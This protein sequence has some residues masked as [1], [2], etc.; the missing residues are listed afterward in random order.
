[1]LA[2]AFG[3]DEKGGGDVKFPAGVATLDAEAKSQLE[4]IAKSLKDRPALKLTVAGSASTAQEAQGWKAANLEAQ[5]AK[6]GKG[7]EDDAAL[8]DKERDSRLKSIYRKADIEKPRNMVGLSKSLPPEEMR[9]LLVEQLPL[10]PTAMQELAAAR[11]MA[12]RSY[13]GQQGID[14]ARLFL[15]DSKADGK[16]A[17]AKAQ[18]SLAV[19]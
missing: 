8:S 11:A 18:L 16:E 13:L 2:G 14:M 9:K 3:G 5:I 19:Q 17:G 4:K 1:M 6:Q 15:G 12:V 7:D 10:P